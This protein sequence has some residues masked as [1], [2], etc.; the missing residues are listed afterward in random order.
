MHVQAI[1]DARNFPSPMQPHGAMARAAPRSVAPTLRVSRRPPPL[2]A[3]VARRETCSMSATA[4]PGTPPPA[5]EVSPVARES[6]EVNLPKETAATVVIARALVVRGLAVRKLVV[7][8]RVVREPIVAIPEPSPPV[9]P[10]APTR[11]CVG[12][13]MMSATS[14]AGM[15]EVG[16]VVLVNPAVPVELVGP[17]AA[18]VARASVPITLAATTPNTTLDF[19]TGAMPRRSAGVGTLASASGEVGVGAAVGAGVE[20]GAGVRATLT[21]PGAGVLPWGVSAGPPRLDRSDGDGVTGEVLGTTL[22]SGIRLPA[23]AIPSGLPRT[24]ASAWGAWAWAGTTAAG[25]GSS[26][27]V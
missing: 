9:P 27:T 16:P 5:G 19:A 22:P 8:R 10:A 12:S 17:D 21:L 4:P 23:G 20:A 3:T 13:A 15:A 18:P 7:Q 2:A 24:A 1:P 11:C 26:A 14:W 25:P 6:S